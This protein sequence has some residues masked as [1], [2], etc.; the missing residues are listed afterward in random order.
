MRTPYRR[1]PRGLIALGALAASSL[2]L[3]AC[4]GGSGSSS[5]SAPAPESSAA[6]S[7]AAPAESSEAPAADGLLA[8]ILE[9]GVLRVSTDPAYP[10]QS[11]YDE[12]TGEWEGF[13]IDVATEIATRMGVT[14]QWETPSWDVITAGNWNDRWDVSVGSMSITEERAQVLD[15]TEPYYFTPAGV[16]VNADSDIQSIDQLAGKR[17]GV[18]GA[19]TYEYYLTRTLVIPGFNFEF[20]VPEDVEIVTYDTDTTA[21]QD[22]KLGRVEAMVSAV[23]LL[24]EAIK[25]G[26]EIRLVGDPVFLEPLAV[27]A[28]KSSTLPVD[29]LVAEM[30]R[31]IAEMHADGTLTELSMKWYGVDITKG[32]GA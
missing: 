30:N 21:L 10:P 4:G 28:D 24:E 32:P 12:A 27:A 17:V 11:S 15:F 18:C 7:S 23:P 3:V 13:D 20:V 16:A 5:S 8:R 14:T 6:E 22:L 19:C 29:S 26:K 9:D 2:L 31:I 1:S 25:K